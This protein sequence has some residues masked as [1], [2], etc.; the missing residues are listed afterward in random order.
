MGQIITSLIN[1][2]LEIGR[3]GDH[4][5]TRRNKSRASTILW[6]CMLA[7]AFFITVESVST[8]YKATGEVV[9]LKA[10]IANLEHLHRD[11]TAL[12]IRNDILSYTLTLYIGQ[13]LVEKLN[14]NSLED[15]KAT[16]PDKLP[17]II[18]PTIPPHIP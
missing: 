18:A 14:N 17:S 2:L 3:S 8:A 12:K 10:T 6:L 9:K 15:L 11:N 4:Y 5:K 13:P 16:L 7:I 1:F